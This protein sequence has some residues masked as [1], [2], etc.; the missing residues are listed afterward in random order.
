M[1]GQITLIQR[2]SMIATEFLIQKDALESAKSILLPEI[3]TYVT[4]KEPEIKENTIAAYMSKIA[5]D[6]D[7]SIRSAG[8]KRGFYV[9]KLTPESAPIPPAASNLTKLKN[10]Q[11]KAPSAEGNNWVEE[12]LYDLISA[13]LEAEGYQAQV[14]SDLTKNGKWGNPDVT[15]LKVTDTVAETKEIEIATVEVK[16]SE[17]DWRQMIFEAVSHT[18]FANV[19]YFAIA[20]SESLYENL[21]DEIYLYAEEYGIGLVGIIMADDDYNKFVSNELQP[22]YA[23]VEIKELRTPTFRQ[24]RPYFREKFLKSLKITDLRGV[25]TW[26]S[27]RRK[28]S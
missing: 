15:G 20:M 2:I 18:R 8:F 23:S 7:S 17:K 9:S 13:W 3:V 10:T 16:S 6:P 22:T 27:V 4:A 1:D 11:P 26:G 21:E 5:R 19:V 14:T 24:L 25:F 28:A 12:K